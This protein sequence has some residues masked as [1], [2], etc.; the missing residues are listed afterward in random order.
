MRP[1]RLYIKP[2]LPRSLLGRSLII[3]VTPLI[4]LQVITSYVFFDRSWDT[5]TRRLAS[6]LAGDISFVVAG[7]IERKEP[8]YQA[9]LLSHARGQFDLRLS[10]TPGEVL[11]IDP[12]PKYDGVVHLRLAQALKERVGRPFRITWNHTKRDLLIAVQLDDGVLHIEAPHERLFSDTSFIFLI[13][14]MGSS[15]ILFIVAMLFMR[16]QVRPI[17]RLAEAV[18]GFGK[19]HDISG[20]KPEGSSEVRQAAA[21]F[22]RMRDRILRQIQQRT[23]M[24]AGVSHDLRTPLTRMKL[25]LAM[26]KPGPEVDALRTDVIEMERMVEGYLAFARG[27]DAEAVAPVDLA[28][29]MQEVIETG[30]REGGAIDFHCEGPITVPI[31]P[32]AFR[33]AATNLVANAK[34]YGDNVWVTLGHRAHA[35]EILIDD[36]GPGIPESLREEVF[37]PFYRIEESRNPETGGIGLGLAIARDAIRRQGGDIVLEDSPHGGLRARVRLPL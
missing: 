19:G 21:A 23:E 33:R 25:E 27:D 7:A 12:S 35:V 16:G 34:R 32:V 13:W 15:L 28:G 2:L 26:V 9:W 5:M 8:D 1:L 14:M 20:F 18:D 11:Q 6:G 29:L 31:R 22:D 24:L 30:R 37:R 17:R 10:V 4:L 36:D 3:I